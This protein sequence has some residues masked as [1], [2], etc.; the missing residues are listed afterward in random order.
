MITRFG[1][2]NFASFKDGAEISF[3][4]PRSTD[5][6]NA[7]STVIG[8]KGA[9]GSGKTN[10]LKAITFLYCF[11]SNR[12]SSSENKTDG[13][14]E[15]SIPI[16]SFYGSAEPIEFYIELI[17][18]NNT[19]YY[20]LDINEKSILREEIRRKKPT[21][22]VTCII[23]EGNKVTHCL[24][25]FE[26]LKKIKIKPNQS[27]IHLHSIY[28]FHKSMPDLETLR[29]TFFSVIFNVGTNGYRT[30]NIED[31]FITSEFYYE[32]PIALDFTKKI[33]KSIDD[34]ISDI[35]IEKATDSQ[36][37]NP[38]YFPSFHHNNGENTYAV[39]LKNESMGTKSLFLYLYRYWLTLKNGSLLILDEFDTHL[40]SMIL[41]ELIALF[42]NKTIN[43]KNAQLIFTAH[44]TEIID[45]L[46]RYRSI[47]V[48][49][50]ENESYCYRLDEVSMLRNDRPISP[51]YLKGKIGGVPKDIYKIAEKASET[52]EAH[53]DQ[54][55]Q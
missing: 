23:R 30:Q 18:N 19:Y 14:R 3:E 4:N 27:I 50:E 44:N 42:E 32:N 24:N 17:I 5:S 11:C 40:H 31:F 36:T 46:G 47:L 53:N 29:L 22:E 1:F 39:S 8:L 48:N 34:G 13:S 41:P 37:G 52:A 7:I 9:N 12:M 49:K 51:F 45:S 20:E 16:E 33:I 38:I 25:E 35:T 26:E 21:K 15:P 28:E 43:K 54:E 6:D 55:I 10:I 2:K